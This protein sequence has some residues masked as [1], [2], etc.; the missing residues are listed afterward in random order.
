VIGLCA[1]DHQT[2][3]KASAELV[4]IL[5]HEENVQHFLNA[6]KP[7]EI[8]AMIKGGKNS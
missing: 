3:L 7:E 1:V 2:H 5:S 4:E 8:L 6:E